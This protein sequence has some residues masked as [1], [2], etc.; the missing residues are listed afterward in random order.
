MQILAIE[1]LY[2]SMGV[3]YKDV[4]RIDYAELSAYDGEHVVLPVSFPFLAYSRDLCITIFSEKIIPVFLSLCILDDNLCDEEVSYLKN[5]SPIGCRDLRTLEIMKQYRIPAYLNGCMTLTF[6]KR[7]EAGRGNKVICVDVP[8]SLFEA[9]PRHILEEAEF[10]SPICYRNELASHPEDAARDLYERY[11]A[12]ARLIIT[13]RLHV[14]LPCMAAGVPVVF[15]KND[16]SFRFCGIDA[17]VPFYDAEH[18]DAIDWDPRPLDLESH[19]QEVL[20]VAMRR[21][22][23]TFDR[24]NDLYCL[25]DRLEN[26]ASKEWFI[27]GVDNTKKS[28]ASHWKQDDPI[29]YIIWGVTQTANV[30]YRYIGETYPYALLRGVIDK[31]KHVDFHGIMSCPKENVELSDNT[32]VLVCAAAAIKEAESWLSGKKLKGYFFCYECDDG[33]VNRSACASGE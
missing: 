5:F 13:T 24:W 25:S 16:H 19:K 28:L 32:Y 9:I 12:E 18:F 1:N 6:P 11:I 30:L 2:R 22:E 27:E 17:V 21:V 7:Q 26:C 3:D 15:L 33:L 14:A 20:R 29:E 4:V 8:E 31:T 23:G 10:C